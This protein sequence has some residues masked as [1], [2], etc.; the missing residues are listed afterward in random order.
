MLM[1]RGMLGS[2]GGAVGN[3]TKF[4]RVTVTPEAAGLEITNPLGVVPKLVVVTGTT[5]TT[6]KILNAVVSSEAI[7]G[8][9]KYT[10]GTTGYST[11]CYFTIDYE[12]ASTTDGRAYLGAD[13]IHIHRATSSR[14]WS[15]MQYTVEIYA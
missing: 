10:E 4:A 2:S 9:Y 11:G 15:V 12:A 5:T 6:N 1:R 8:G 3:F 14:T 13:K 7:V